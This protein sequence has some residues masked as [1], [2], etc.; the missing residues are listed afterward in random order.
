MLNV[1]TMKL[2]P[3]SPLNGIRLKQVLDLIIVNIK[4]KNLVRS[5]R[6]KLLT[7]MR[8]TETSG[9]DHAY[10]HRLNRFTVQIQSIGSVRHILIV[11]VNTRDL[12]HASTEITMGG[13][14]ICENGR[15]E[16][17]K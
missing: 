3:T 4:R 6:H 13:R 16:R 10:R 9:T 14:E 8:A 12:S 17:K 11:S 2:D 5:L 15:K 7:E 1:D